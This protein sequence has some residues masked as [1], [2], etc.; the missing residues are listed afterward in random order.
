MQTCIFPPIMQG[1]QG[2]LT[3]VSKDLYRLLRKSLSIVNRHAKFLNL[4]KADLDWM[5]YR[6]IYHV[7]KLMSHN[8]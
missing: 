2:K 8:A 6:C 4:G 1:V 3:I 5:Y 7:N